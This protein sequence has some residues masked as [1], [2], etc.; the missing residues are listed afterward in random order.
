MPITT[1][2]STAALRQAVRSV[3][4]FEALKGLL[5][6]CAMFGLLRLLHHDLHHLALEWVDHL[7]LSSHPGFAA[8]LLQSADRLNTTPVHTLVLLGSAYTAARWLEAWG[9]WRDK[10]WGEWLGVLSCGL[11]L[12]L[13][14]AHLLHKPSWQAGL[15]L[16]VNLC[17][18]AVLAL[19]LRQRRRA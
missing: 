17:L 9:L 3:A 4:I 12:P 5:A 11:Y 13:E 14:I 8:L 10:A 16:L 2:S 7:G 19:R 6:I 15:V 1:D 18:I